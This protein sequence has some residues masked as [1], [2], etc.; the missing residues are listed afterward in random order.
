MSMTALGS[1]RTMLRALS[2]V[3]AIISIGASVTT[4]PAITRAVPSNFPTIQSAINA[5]VHGDTVLVAPGTYTGP[6]NRDIKFNGKRIVVRSEVGAESTIIDCQGTPSDRHRGFDFS[7]IGETNE[8]I[9]DGFTIMNGYPDDGRGGGIKIRVADPLIRNCKVIDCVGTSGAAVYCLSGGAILQQCVFSNNV[10]P[11]MFIN[12]VGLVDQCAI[13][14]NEGMGIWMVEGE[15]RG[16][17]IAGN[18]GDGIFLDVGSL[19]IIRDCLITGNY[20]IAVVT[21]YVGQPLIEGCT[22]VGNNYPGTGAIQLHFTTLMT[23]RRSIIRDNC[24]FDVEVLEG[25]G[26]RFECC[27]VNP[28]GVTGAGTIFYAGPQVTQDPQLCSLISCDDAPT[29]LGDFHLQG[30]SPCLP[31]NSP[32]GELIGALPDGCSPSSVPNGG[33]PEHVEAADLLISPNPITRDGR[34]V[35]SLGSDREPDTRLSSVLTDGT[36]VEV[37]VIDAGGRE[38][39]RTLQEFRSEGMS[40]DAVGLEAGAYFVR[41][42]AND[43]QAVGRFLRLR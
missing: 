21:W 34:L 14:D 31:E 28:P 19:P 10:G 11:V 38:R 7:S 42:R 8:S 30:T 26:I 35:I 24:W 1:R 20:G 36:T 15:I 13:T 32:C 22:I 16:S 12:D 6:G 37:V 18:N 2:V 40:I 23:C 33:Q 3:G 4:A 17:T 43:V 39:L 41:V 29:A 9:L 27:A 25:S 5:S